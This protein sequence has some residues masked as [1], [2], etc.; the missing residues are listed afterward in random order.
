MWKLISNMLLRL[1]KTLISQ[2]N[3]LENLAYFAY[4]ANSKAINII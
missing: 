2:K 1:D 4:S 3:K